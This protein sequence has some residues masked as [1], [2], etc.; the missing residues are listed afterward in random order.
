MGIHVVFVLHAP[1]TDE[2]TISFP[3]E[4]PVDCVY[5]K[6]TNTEPSVQNWLNSWVSAK[7]TCRT[8]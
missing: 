3:F 6:A 8:C 1:P 7:Q 2:W 4:E 5:Y